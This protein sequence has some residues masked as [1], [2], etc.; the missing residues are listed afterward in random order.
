MNTLNSI[1]FLLALSFLISCEDPAVNNGSNT[2]SPDTGITSPSSGNDR[3]GNTNTN[4]NSGDS[5]AVAG[6]TIVAMQKDCEITDTHFDKNVFVAKDVAQQ[7]SIIATAATKDEDLGDSHRILRVVNTTDCST[8]LEKTLPIN[9]SADFP[10]YLVPQTYESA[11]QIVAI[12]GFS[13]TYYF[14]VKNKQ[15]IGPVEPQFLT[16]KAAADAQSGMVKGLTIW[17]HYLLGRSVDYGNFAFD[18]TDPS[19]PKPIL[20]VAEYLIPK[21]E[22]YNNLFILDTGNGFSQAILPITD[23]DAGGNFFKLERMFP[24][25]L[26]VNTTIAKNVQNNRFIIFNDSTDPGK[27]KKVVI[28]MF[29]KKRIDLPESM[30]TKKTGEILEWL[31]NQK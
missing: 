13:S 28:D 27:Q 4:G 5:A 21:T 1:I 8:I 19:K 29:G 24:Q 9:R 23:I 2:T 14:D 7:M 22:E 10:Y 3:M 18:I 26:K 20:P 6:E 31:K 12:Q 25:P 11:N 17:G 15:L 16:N 30:A